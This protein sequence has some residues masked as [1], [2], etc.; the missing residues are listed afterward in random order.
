MDQ[1]QPTAN[2]RSGANGG[3]R[4]VYD[5]LRAQMADGSLAV[6]ARL[7]STRALAADLGVA[8]STVTVAYEQLAAEGFVATAP[9]RSA[10][11]RS[12]PMGS[13]WTHWSC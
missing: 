13:A 9:G 7:P 5:L 10:P 12:R 6:G 2:R 4:R 1:L 8:R 3:G 11:R